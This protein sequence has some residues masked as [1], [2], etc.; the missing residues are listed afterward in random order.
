MGKGAT[1]MEVEPA[2]KAALEVAAL[3][4]E[5]LQRLGLISPAEVERASEIQPLPKAS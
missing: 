3:A 5:I 2:G 1:V 4:G